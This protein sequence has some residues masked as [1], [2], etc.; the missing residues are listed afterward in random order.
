M[1]SMLGHHKEKKISYICFVFLGYPKHIFLLKNMFFVYFICLKLRL[2][3]PLEFDIFLTENF[4]F[5]DVGRKSQLYQLSNSCRIVSKTRATVTTAIL[6]WRSWVNLVISSTL[7]MWR[8]A[9]N[10]LGFCCY[11]KKCKFGSFN[12]LRPEEHSQLWEEQNGL[13]INGFE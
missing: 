7:F 13:N 8:D 4:I 2:R 5:P 6:L 11:R 9:N 1:P 10:V 12:I 3:P